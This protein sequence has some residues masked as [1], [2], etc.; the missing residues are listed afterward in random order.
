MVWFLLNLDVYETVLFYIVD[1]NLYIEYRLTKQIV[2]LLK[3]HTFYIDFHVIY[4]TSH[5]IYEHMDM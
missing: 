1:E 2:Q 3:Y 5:K 4:F